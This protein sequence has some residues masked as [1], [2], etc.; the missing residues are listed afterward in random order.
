[1]EALE[2]RLARLKEERKQLPVAVD[3]DHA[4]EMLAQ[5]QEELFE[6]EAR[7]RAVHGSGAVS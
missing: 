7:K 2:R 3:M 1:M 4:L 5:A 6:A